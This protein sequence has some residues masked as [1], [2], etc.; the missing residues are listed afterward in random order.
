MKKSTALISQRETE[1]SFAA[2]ARRYAD[3]LDDIS[4]RA[5]DD[6]SAKIDGYSTALRSY[7]SWIDSPTGDFTGSDLSAAG[8]EIGNT[9]GVEQEGTSSAPT[10]DRSEALTTL[11]RLAPR[12]RTVTTAQTDA[13]AEAICES[14]RTQ[15]GTLSRADRANISSGMTSKESVAVITYAVYTACP[16]FT[17]DLQPWVDSM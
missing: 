13:F 17:S 12:F 15:G 4:Q 8:L 1:A 11:K 14:L 7:A 10:V 3:D 9:C 2:E 6:M 16:E 5:G